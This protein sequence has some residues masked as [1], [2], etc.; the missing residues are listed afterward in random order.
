MDVVKGRTDIYVNDVAYTRSG[1]RIFSKAG[2][3][4]SKF[5]KKFIE[6]IQYKNRN[7]QDIKVLEML[8][9]ISTNPERRIS[10]GA[11][12]YRC[13]IIE[14]ISKTGKEK[15]FFGYGKS[16]SFVPPA[17]RTSDLRA[18]YRYIPYLYCANDPYTALVEVRPRLGSNVSV[19]TIIVNT[20]LTLLDFTLKNIPK[21]MRESKLNLFADL[22][23]LYSKPVAS[24]DDTLDYIPTQFVAE[25]AKRLGYDGIAFRSSLTPELS[26][27]DVYKDE[28]MDRYNIVVFNY[29]KCEPIA[30]NIVNI[31]RNYLECEQ[32]DEATRRI[33]IHPTILDMS[34]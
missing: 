6:E 4:K 12:L 15:S 5:L 24:D 23:I 29:Q 11:N 1:D 28:N 22:S 14:D 17:E 25:Y 27:Q 34:Y 26:N 13:R 32:I 31:T 33:D 16:D 30:S 8:K 19:A 9:D 10:V 18:N 3:I 2:N 7:P 21:R 20:E